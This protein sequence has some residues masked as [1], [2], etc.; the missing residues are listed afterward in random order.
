[1]D[2]WEMCTEPDCSTS[3]RPEG[4]GTCAPAPIS[5]TAPP[6]RLFEAARRR[7]LLTARSGEE[8]TAPK[9]RR[10]GKPL[11]RCDHRWEDRRG[12]GQAPPTAVCFPAIGGQIPAVSGITSAPAAVGSSPCEG[13]P[14]TAHRL[15]C[16]GSKIPQGQ[17]VRRTPDDRGHCT[18]R[19]GEPP[20][21]IDAMPDPF[22]G[23]DDRRRPPRGPKPW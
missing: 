13:W 6:D 16:S 7:S 3:R 15:P 23:P 18:V 2:A 9:R 8:R 21:A 5:S 11:L 4:V 14:R 12:G 20:R 1:M 22:A 19:G 10:L 17:A